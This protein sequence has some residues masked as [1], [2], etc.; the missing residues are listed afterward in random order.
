MTEQEILKH[1]ND[2]FDSVNLIN[3]LNAK[4]SLT[5][6]ETKDKERNQWHLSLMI[7]KDWFLEALTDEQEQQILNVL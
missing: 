3:G 5:A 4:E 2:A 6:D 7:E 1:V